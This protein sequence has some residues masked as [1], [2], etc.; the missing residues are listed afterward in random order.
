MSTASTIGTKIA[1]VYVVLEGELLIDAPLGV[2]WRYVVDYPSWQDYSRVETVSGER[3][4]EGE[5]VLLIKEEEG[6][7]FPPYYARIIKLDPQLRFL[8]KTWP[9]ETSDENDFFGIV[10]FRVEDAGDGRT[11]FT[12][13]TLYEFNVRYEHEDELDAVRKSQEQNFANLT[14]AVMPKLK[15]IAEANASA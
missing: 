1:P 15:K 7:E 11:R 5:V 12:Y 14:S 6:F 9:V 13:N 3:G 10:D 8:S 4:Q 2:T